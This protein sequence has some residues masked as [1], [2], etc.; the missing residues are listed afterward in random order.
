MSLLHELIAAKMTG[1]GGGGGGSD[2]PLVVTVNSQ[3]GAASKTFSEISSALAAGRSV[4]FVVPVSGVYA[5]LTTV[6]IL[7]GYAIQATGVADLGN[8]PTLV[9]YTLMAN[10][11]G[12]IS[13]RSVDAVD[14]I[15]LPGTTYTLAPVKYTSYECGTLT[16]LTITN[17]PADGSW[18]VRFTSGSTATVLTMPNTVVMPDGFEVEA[19]TV[20]E[21][22]V[23]DNYALVASWPVAS[24]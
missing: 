12:A 13:T 21:I 22:N 9:I 10:G 23:L 4:V 19:N 3:T 7:E 6:G 16:S 17:P 24:S 20:Y 18:S 15:T 5:Y 11:T 2:G 8:T 14:V 1:G